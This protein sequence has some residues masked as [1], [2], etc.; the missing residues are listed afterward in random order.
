MRRFLWIG[1]VCLFILSFVFIFPPEEK[2]SYTISKENVSPR[3]VSIAFVGDI[4]L[5]RSVGKIIKEED[6]PSYPFGVSKDFF[7]DKNIVF[8]NLET[9]ISYRG[10]DMGSVYSFRSDPRVVEGLFDSHFSILSL[11]NNHIYDW[12]AEALMDTVHILSQH[13]IRSIGAGRDKDEA[14]GIVVLGENPRISFFAC[15]DIFGEFARAGSGPGLFGCDDPVVFDRVEESI[16]ISDIQVV[17]LHWGEE[18]EEYNQRQEYLAHRLIDAGVDIVVGHH[19]HVVQDVA[20]YK[21]GVIFYSLGNFIFDQY[22][23]D[24]TMRGMIGVVEVSLDG[25]ESVSLFE[26]NL[27]KRYQVQNITP[28][29]ATLQ[30]EDFFVY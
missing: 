15:S 9:P 7:S 16:A 26:S 10:T 12:G 25:I 14:S 6:D 30:S 24:E 20:W 22:F 19:P 11:A 2:K 18:Y 27:S 3:S 29:T 8:G 28:H 21:G 4:M 17:S 23:S 5:S 13:G 1:I